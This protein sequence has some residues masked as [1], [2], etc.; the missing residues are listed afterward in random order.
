MDGR[1]PMSVVELRFADAQLIA[2]GLRGDRQAL[3]RLFSQHRSFLL[4]L[5]CRIIGHREESEDVVQKSLLLAYRKLPSFKNQG[6]FRSWLGRIVVNEA[7]SFLRQRKN[8]R[9]NQ[10][11]SLETTPDPQPD[12]EQALLR[13]QEM[14]AIRRKVY[15]LP[16]RQRSAL[17]LCELYECTAQ[18]AGTILKAP[19]SAL[20]SRLFRARKH[21]A[22]SLHSTPAAE[23]FF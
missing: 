1:E 10:L 7:F 18:E 6:T 17:I 11:E 4:K 13:K 19:P 22:A 3:D 20:R 8:Q 21:L 5:A 15:E 9:L 23:R 14:I 12:P 2:D 16:F